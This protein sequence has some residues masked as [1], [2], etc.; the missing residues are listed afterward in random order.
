[1]DPSSLERKA[2]G[3]GFSSG[4]R[5]CASAR[6]AGGLHGVQEIPKAPSAQKV[7]GILRP[8]MT[9]IGTPFRPRHMLYWGME[10]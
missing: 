5:Q 2:P 9:V 6:S 4:F 1:M 10:P 3:S 7:C 8:D